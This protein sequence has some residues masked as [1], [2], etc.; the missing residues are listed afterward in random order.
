MSN[1]LKIIVLVIVILTGVPFT[2][3]AVK[4]INCGGETRDANNQI[5]SVD[6]CDFNDLLVTIITVINYLI[7]VAAVVAMY[8][9]LLSGFNLITSMGN[10]DKIQKA[11]GSISNAVVGFAIVVL[12]FVFV[13]LLVN[14]LLGDPNATRKWWDPKCVYNITGNAT[15][16]L[17]KPK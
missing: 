6:Q 8:Y 13:N 4:F 5:T 9:I 3:Q 11:K 14:G 17:I 2:A 7:S 15:C 10:P 1:R 16:P 12:A